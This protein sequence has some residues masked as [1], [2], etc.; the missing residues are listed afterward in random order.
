MTTMI[1]PPTPIPTQSRPT[2]PV[3]TQPAPAVVAGKVRGQRR[4]ANVELTLPSRFDV[5]VVDAFSAEVDEAIA[6]DVASLTIDATAIKHI[7]NTGLEALAAAQQQTLARWI[8]FELR[9]SST[10]QIACELTGSSMDLHHDAT[11]TMAV[12]A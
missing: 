12:A 1:H 10:L 4:P 3:P 8:R 11:A 6:N 7:D 9:A 5:H 2:Q